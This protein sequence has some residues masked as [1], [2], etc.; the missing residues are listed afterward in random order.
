V[1]KLRELCRA[2]GITLMPGE[3]ELLGA[4][5]TRQIESGE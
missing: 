4:E 2:G 1:L 3:R 5:L